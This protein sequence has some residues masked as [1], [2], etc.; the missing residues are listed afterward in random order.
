MELA[1]H[2]QHIV[3]AVDFSDISNRAFE[4]AFSIA[5][6]TTGAE[7]HIVSIA[8]RAALE[9]L[10]VGPTQH[11]TLV[12]SAD[13]LRDELTKLTKRS[14]AEYRKLNPESRK[15][16]TFIHVRVGDIAEEITQLASEIGADLIV[17]GTHGRRGLRRVVLGSVAEHVVRFAPCQVLVVRPKDEHAMDGIPGLDPPCPNC[18]AMRKSTGGKTW[19]CEPH[20]AAPRDFHFYARSHRLDD[21]GI[22]F[23]YK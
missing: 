20:Q 7:L 6:R 1:T 10:G 14:M 19:W 9:F 8:D 3:V 16:P 2:A 15:V 21:E 12:E 17:V 23:P 5:R 13:R 18:V 4:Q 11:P 22:E